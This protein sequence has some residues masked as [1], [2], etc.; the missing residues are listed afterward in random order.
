MDNPDQLKEAAKLVQDSRRILVI[1]GAGISAEAGLPTYRGVGGLYNDG[2]THEGMA[3]EDALSGETFEERPDLTWRYL[4]QIE[5]A[6][7]GTRPSRAHQILAELERSS[8]VVILTQNVDG[9]HTLAGSTNVIDIH[10]DYRDLRCTGCGATQ[11]VE[12]YAGLQVPPR[13]EKCQ[14]VIRPEVVLFGEMLPMRKLDKLAQESRKG[15]D[16]YLSIGTSSLFPYIA[17][18]MLYA[19]N[20]GKPTIEINPVE[21]TISPFMRFR[22]AQ[23][24]GEVL[25]QLTRR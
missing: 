13:C 2:R 6:C 14:G 16:L 25:E 9:L 11:R 19:A 5:A 15:F 21:T 17:G 20:N 3:I 18:P 24:A 8:E 22:F 1:T 10:G 23:K 4:T 7:R 12:D